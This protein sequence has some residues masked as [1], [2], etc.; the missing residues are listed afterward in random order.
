MSAPRILIV[1]PST[2]N[3]PD[4]LGTWLAHTT[5]DVTIPSECELPQDL[6][7]YDALL[8]L[9]GEMSARDD[10]HYP[11]LSR[12][13]SLLSH[14]V[15]K[16]RP[17]LAIGLG[18]QLLA[19]ATGGQIREAR[20]GPEVGTLL[21]AKRDVAWEDPLFGSV[22][23]TPD[24][25]QFHSEEIST[26]PPSAQLLASA[27]NC[28]NQVFRVGDCAYG[29]QFHIETTTST[30]LS[31]VREWPHLAELARPSDLQPDHLDQFHMAMAET[32]QPVAEQFTRIVATPP[33]ERGAGRYLPLV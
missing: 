21:I 29:L 28:E 22:P 2:H 10:I 16:R 31:W 4:A 3:P 8:V 7:E 27:P 15:S 1:Q 30:V 32:W 33:D 14:A 20:K 26:L 18:A 24:V 11:W 6:A 25:L 19:M 12:I 13:R 9:G 5:L 23:L 17:V